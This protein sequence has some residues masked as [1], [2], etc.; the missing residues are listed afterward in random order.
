MW[1]NT[2]E[3]FIKPNL[4]K[5]SVEDLLEG[6]RWIGG[7]LNRYG[8]TTAFEAAIRNVIETVAWQRLR[9]EQRLPLRVVLGPYPVYGDK[10]EANTTGGKMFD[11]GFA[12]GFGDGWLKF[13]AVQI[14]IDGGVIGQTAALSKPYSNDPTGTQ[15]GSFRLDQDAANQLMLK[16]HSNNWQA[17]LICHGDR[18]IMRGLDAVAYARTQA[19]NRHLRHRLEHAYLWNP[20]AMDRMAELGV[21][22]N[23]QPVLMEIVGREGVYSQWGDRAR[24]AFPFKSLIK[25]GVIISGGSDWPVGLYNPLIGIDILVNHRFGPEEN[26]EVLNSEE[27][28]SVLQALRV[29]TYNGAYTA[30]EEDE[31]GSLEEGK[32]ADMAVLSDDI[33]SVSATKIREIKIDQ[34][35]VDG[36]LVFERAN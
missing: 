11:T 26:S 2:R 29:Y 10:W 36:R 30:F 5:Y 4:P 22:W 25:R 13:G 28:L 35:Y 6:Y 23:T 1:D 15:Y 31:K 9:L 18:G 17:G 16:V 8:I 33:L 14:G 7:E 24:F 19:P 12:T 34:T 21:I 3:V 32:L 27:G 20:E